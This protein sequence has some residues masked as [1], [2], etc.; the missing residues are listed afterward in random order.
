MDVSVHVKWSNLNLI[1]YRQDLLR[2]RLNA[3]E[4]FL[5]RQQTARCID[6]IIYNDLDHEMMH[7]G[8]CPQEIVIYGLEIGLSQLASSFT[9]QRN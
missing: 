2:P 1:L 9:E 7:A 8:A 6:L 4:G 3:T 5:F